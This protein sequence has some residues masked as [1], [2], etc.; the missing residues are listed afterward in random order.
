MGPGAN[1]RESRQAPDR[2]DRSRDKTCRKVKAWGRRCKPFKHLMTQRQSSRMALAHGLHAAQPSEA[3]TQA[4]QRAFLATPVASRPA[5][6]S[7]PGLSS[8]ARVVNANGEFARPPFSPHSS[9]G[10][11][12]AASDG[13]G[14]AC[15][16]AFGRR[17]SPQD[18]PFAAAALLTKNRR[19]WKA[20]AE[21]RLRPPRE[22]A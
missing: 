2:L 16:C 18:A 17:R 6:A 14:L 8:R 7:P 15:A 12:V 1:G 4:L 3:A 21:H 9:A 10:A 19:W 22:L 11:T 13:R 5:P 20:H